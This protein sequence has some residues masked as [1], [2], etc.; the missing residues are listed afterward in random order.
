M[1]PVPYRYT[2]LTAAL[3]DKN[4]PLRRYLDRRFPLVKPFQADY[5]ANAGSLLVDGADANPG[6][7][8]AAFDYLVRFVLD[9]AYVPE[10]ALAAFSHEPTRLGPVG[11]VSAR[12]GAAT[13]VP[14]RE[15]DET[16]AAR[17]CWAL[18]LC[19]EVY[20][21]GGVTPGSSLA[22][23]LDERRFTVDGMMALAPEAAIRQLKEL[24]A[25]AEEA[26]LPAV[27]DR[28]PLS[29]GPTFDGSTLCAADA[30]IIAGDLLIE[31]KTYL[32]AKNPRTGVRSDGLLT[33]D[34]YQPISYAL[35]DRSDAYNIRSVA[36]YSARYG[37]LVTWPLETALNTMA[38]AEVDLREEREQI[39][40][41][42]GGR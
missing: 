30:D 31:L 40:G 41:L 27:R 25:V 39:W 23:L 42:L 19:T 7:L 33:V 9:S 21:R 38:G 8:G 5:R 32:G 13:E 35:F 37:H 18:A 26:L 2:S 12:A 11:E 1:N 36:I 16:T 6:T 17:A 4:S 24:Y 20:R 15:Q 22:D 29:L 14:Y 10:P 3:K 34:L 28:R